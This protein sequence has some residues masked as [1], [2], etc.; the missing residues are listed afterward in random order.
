MYNLSADSA[1]FSG[2]KFLRIV[3]CLSSD[4]LLFLAGLP[5]ELFRVK[6]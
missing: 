4:S 5:A 6:G 2:E 3:V 1:R